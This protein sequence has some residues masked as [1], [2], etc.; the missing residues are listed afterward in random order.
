MSSRSDLTR[1][2][3]QLSVVGLVV[4][5]AAA[6]IVVARTADRAIRRRADEAL[7]ETARRTSLV[8][9]RVLAERRHELG[10][11]A[12]IPGVER[13]AAQASAAHARLSPGRL[14]DAELELRLGESP[15]PA[16][17]ELATTLVRIASQSML[18]DLAVVDRYGVV[19]GTAASSGRKLARQARWWEQALLDGSAQASPTVDS[20]S[21]AATVDL[22]AAIV[23]PGASEP[24]GVVHGVLP[25][26][27]L[28]FILMEDSSLADNV[29][30]ELVDENRRVVFSNTNPFRVGKPM[31]PD[32]LLVDAALRPIREI[33]GPK[34]AERVAM[35]AMSNP[36]WFVVLRQP[37]AGAG[38]LRDGIDREGLQE[39]LLLLALGILTLVGLRAWLKRRVIAPIQAIE[40]VATQVAHGNLATPDIALPAAHDEVGRLGR[41]IQAM[42]GAL[43]QL[44]RSIS[45]GAHEV[46]ASAQQISSATQEMS[47]S[48]QQVATTTTELT[49]RASTQA[50]QVRAA[51]DDA[52]KILAIAAELAN[53][54]VEAA[55]RNARLARMAREHLERLDGST[56]ELLRLTEELEQGAR[57]AEELAESSTRIENFVAQTRAIAKQTHM[58]ALNAA[59]EAARGDGGGRGFGVV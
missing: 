24:A 31:Q 37:V 1:R 49:S 50:D 53:G 46:A 13:A 15:L 5:G 4:I 54:A 57:E 56:A 52:Q 21:G 59:I 9:Q 26:E 43:Q 38:S 23:P 30:L 47:A 19:I 45:G 27:K 39:L 17:P 32:S 36:A 11:I 58:L 12:R 14:S 25:L 29:S 6:A 10:L 51:A 20:L 40:G 22:A 35:A 28:G 3:S 18:G 42:V 2:V 33:A 34:G 8:V 48:T 44:A 16:N 41:A 55:H 7:L